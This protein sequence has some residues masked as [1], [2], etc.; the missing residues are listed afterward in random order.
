MC[1]MIGDAEFSEVSSMP[2]QD[3]CD[4]DS[5]IRGQ[6]L[7]SAPVLNLYLNVR[8]LHDDSASVWNREIE[9]TR[10]GENHA[11]RDPPLEQGCGSAHM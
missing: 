11:M 9:R 4:I 2:A 1:S 10:A 5:P 6:T 8:L 7:W 3:C